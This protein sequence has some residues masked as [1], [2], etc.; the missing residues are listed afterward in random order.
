MSNYRFRLQP[1]LNLKIQEEEELQKKLVDCR[2]RFKE[3]R[4]SLLSLEAD[5]DRYLRQLEEELEANKVDLNSTRWSHKYLQYLGEEITRL[6]L[7]I[8]QLERELER[9]RQ[10][11]LD[12]TKEKKSLEKLKEKVK[13]AH[14]R[15][16]LK[17]E[18]KRIDELAQS[19]YLH[20]DQSSVISGGN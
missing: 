19:R 8:Q 2:R 13:A 5:K 3:K 7:Q 14:K 10:Q 16:L 1:L 4:D 9:R 20:Y 17:Q 6:S 15:E 11:L 18:Q 12:K